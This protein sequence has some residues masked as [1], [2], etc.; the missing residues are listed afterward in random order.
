[1]KFTFHTERSPHTSY[2]SH[3]TLYLIL[4]CPLLSTKN[5]SPLLPDY[6]KEPKRHKTQHRSGCQKRD[7]AYAHVDAVKE[8]YATRSCLIPDFVLGEPICSP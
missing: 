8:T 7:V 2:W 6:A 1:M 4:L 5:G 3:Y